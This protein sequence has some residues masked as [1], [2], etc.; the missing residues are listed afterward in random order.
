MNKTVSLAIRNAARNKRRSI[1]TVLAIAVGAASIILFGGYKQSMKYGFETNIVQ[2]IGHLHI[3]RRGFFS[4]GAGNPSHYSIDNYQ[5]LIDS[6]TGDPQLRDKLTVT[7]PVISLFGIAGNYAK[8]ASKTFFGR[9]IVPS[10]KAAINKWND[11]GIRL[12]RVNRTEITD[13]DTEGGIIGQGLARMLRLCD[14]LAVKDCEVQPAAVVKSDNAA[15]EDFSALEEPSTALEPKGQYPRLDLLGA[16]SKG[17]PNVV[18]LFIRKAVNQGDKMTDENYVEMHIDLAKRLVF[19]KDKGRVTGI[20]LQLKHTR[21]IPFVV[22]RLRGRFKAEGLDLETED[23]EQLVPAFGQ[24]ISMFNT[25]FSFIAV[26]MCIIVLFTVVNT[27][28]MSIMERVNEIGT[29]RA[30]GVRRSGIVRLFITE[31]ALL[32]A[33][34]ATVGVIAAVAAGYIINIA[35]LTWMPPFNVEPVYITILIFQ[36][37]WFVPLTWGSLTTLSIVSSFFPARRASRMA[38]VDALR[39]V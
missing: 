28:T 3:Y 18:S 7:T 13:N 37:P 36:E 5:G 22:E 21:D 29:T 14:E 35:G 2:I 4:Y 26:V 34:G 32:G 24:A 1:T 10:D 27:I 9:G 12:Y 20:I 16:S 15:K 17:A 33:T 38:V 11:Y 8:D 30:L 31:G 25:I 19:G 6:I 23:F 39:H